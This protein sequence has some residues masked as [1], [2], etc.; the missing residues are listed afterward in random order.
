MK[1]KSKKSD[2]YGVQIS[3][4]LKKK[5]ELCSYLKELLEDLKGLEQDIQLAP[6]GIN[7][8]A[9]E[10]ISPKNLENPDK[11]IRV[12]TACCIVEIL[13]IYVPDAPYDDRDIL[14]VF[15]V[16]ISQIRGL[17]T[18]ELK[19]EIGKRMFYILT[20]LATVKSC[21]IPVIMA[22]SGDKNAE[23]TVRSLFESITE[24]IQPDHGED[25][26]F[27]YNNFF[28]YLY[29]FYLFLFFCIFYHLV[30]LRSSEI[31]VACISEYED[32]PSDLLE[33]LLIPL[34]PTSKTEN[35]LAYRMAASVL[36]S[37]GAIIEKPFTRMVQSILIGTNKSF[38]ER[39]SEL[40]EEIY[41]IIFELHKISP[42]MLL[43]VIPFLTMQLTVE[44]EEIR[45]KA[46]KL[47]G[48]LY[49]SE[50]HD[51]TK[52]FPKDF[53][54]YLGRLNDLSSNIRNELIDTTIYLLKTKPEVK[55]LIEGKPRFLFG[56]YLYTG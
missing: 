10:L 34:L 3:T 23:E 54:D 37:T 18:N 20:S 51:Y 16:F 35:P 17:Q 52:E 22:L 53:K 7:A 19:S 50:Y 33:L 29:A 36:S 49:S 39:Q 9:L 6:R 43:G 27:L 21:V 14:R 13:R 56:R 40:S 15:E 45:S 24:S 25:G 12:L 1:S 46:V 4:K 5:N 41:S 48:K 42:E 38:H 47:L 44:E 11:E 32:L 55:S 2:L 31:L 28:D 8:T 30:L 26:K